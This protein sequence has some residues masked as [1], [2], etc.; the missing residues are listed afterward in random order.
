[1]LRR[2]HPYEAPAFD[3]VQLAAPPEAVGQGRVG[4]FTPAVARQELFERIKRGLEIGPLLVAGPTEGEV[5]RAACCAGA[6]GEFL[7]DGI[8]QR[9]ELFLT[10]EVR[11]H[12]ALKA[13]R[14]GMTVVCTLHSNSERFA[15]KRL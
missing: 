14:A 9:A 12:D 1:A 15:L 6:C 13:A 3:L 11:H 4:S 7:D 8:A 2:S 10:G 5:S